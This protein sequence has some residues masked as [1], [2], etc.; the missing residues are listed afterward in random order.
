MRLRIL[1]ALVVALP[2]LFVQTAQA[3]APLNLILHNGVIFRHVLEL[4]DRLVLTR[5][6]LIPASQTAFADTFTV[7]VA[8]GDFDDPVTLVN[9]VNVTGAFATDVVVVAGSTTITSS[10]QLLQDEQTVNCLATGLSD[11]SYSVTVTYRSG[12]SAYSA[13][14][15]FIRKLSGATI[16]AERAGARVGCGLVGLYLTASGG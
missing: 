6:S 8:G 16:V 13:Q 14:D 7:S 5:L 4:N 11:A 15:V 10:C 3:A 9:R 1:L 2:L 12:W